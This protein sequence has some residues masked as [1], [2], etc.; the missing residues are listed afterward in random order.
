VFLL[1][2]QKLVPQDKQEE[3]RVIYDVR[4]GGGIPEPTPPPACTTAD[5]CRAAPAPQ[6][7]IFGPPASQTFTGAGNLIPPLHVV[8]PLV[9]PKK[10][11]KGYV[12]KKGKCVKSKAKKAKKARKTNRKGSK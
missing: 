4:V 8:K 12:K 11:K 3:A 5:A 7:S 1:E 9:K 10:C 6:P 2:Y